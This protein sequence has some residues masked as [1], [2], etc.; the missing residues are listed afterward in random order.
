MKA[1][2]QFR[3][4]RRALDG[5]LL[6]DKP[7]GITSNAALQTARRLL[8][9]AKAGHTGTLDPMATGLLPL[10]FG[11]ATKF[12]QM[13][14]DA[15]KEYEATV[16]L[17]IETDTGDA[18]GRPIAEAPVSVSEDDVRTALVRFTGEID[19]VP[20]MYSALKRDGKPLYE[21]A[22]AGIEV[23]LAPRRVTIHALELLEFGGETFRIRVA[24]SK[25]TYIRTLAIDLGRI[26]GC[27]AHLSALRRTRIGPFA[28]GSGAVT[29]AGLEAASAEEREGL[30]APADA[31]V[32]HLPEVALSAAQAAGLLQG[33]ALLLECRERGLVRVY[34]DGRFLGLGELGDDS[35]LLPKRLVAT[36]TTARLS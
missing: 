8:N 18:E 2:K 31:L 33:R 32:A 6:L 10:T 34:G 20:P 17:G 5:V 11:E 9:A 36:G 14:L 16:R 30:L 28:V 35:R 23:E 22:R 24:C 21:Y 13:L 4:Q 25:G 19:Q 15:D 12:S 1:Q 27:G 3:H 29:L 26:L 7:Q